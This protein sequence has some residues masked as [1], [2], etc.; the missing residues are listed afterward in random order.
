MRGMD[1]AVCDSNIA[2]ADGWSRVCD[3]NMVTGS[4]SCSCPDF[5]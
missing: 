2:L 3:S 1:A 4:R 5:S